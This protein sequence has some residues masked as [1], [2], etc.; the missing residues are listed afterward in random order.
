MRK[1]GWKWTL[2]V[3]GGHFWVDFYVNILPP[4][5]PMISGLWGLTNS[6]LGLI[7]SIQSMTAN[8]LQPVLGY[9]MDKNPQKWSLGLAIAI[10]ALPMCLIYL[11]N[12]YLLFIIMVTFAGLGSAL[13][14]PLGASRSVEGAGQDKALKMSVFSSLGSFGFAIS[15]AITAYIVS[16]WGLKALVYTIFPGIL[17]IFLLYLAQRK[18]AVEQNK[19]EPKPV[20]TIC[21][22]M[23]KPLFLL[24]CIVASRSWVV[25]A[26]TIFLPVWMASQGMGDQQAGLYLTIFL[27]AGT[28]GGFL[29]GYIYPFLGQ[30]KVLI[31]AF[32]LSMV[33][34][35][36]IFTAG[37]GLMVVILFLY[38]FFLMGTF[39][40]TVVIG[41]EMLPSRAGLAS[42]MT[43]GLAF[44]LGGLGTAVTGLLADQWGVVT[45]LLLTSLLLIPAIIITYLLKKPQLRISEIQCSGTERG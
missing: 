9:L 10:I 37:P 41:Q 24:S 25:T 38:G 15:P 1:N 22:D 4:I 35:P 40:I 14:H 44:G 12:S 16:I 5:L 18:R 34:L 29:C 6:Q 7:I 23:Y 11:A 19:A 39:P 43:M 2:L 26:S 45:G 32:L 8:F 30:K 31:G 3:A 33:L 20:E 13:Y 17:W 21:L 27:L 36:L 42:G 28:I